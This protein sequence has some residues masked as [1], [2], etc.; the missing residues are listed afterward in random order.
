M[1]E[2]DKAMLKGKFVVV[3]KYIGKETFHINNLS[4]YL[5]NVAKKQEQNKPTVS[6]RKIQ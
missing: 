2:T 3:N 1:W 6:R 4:F 5:K